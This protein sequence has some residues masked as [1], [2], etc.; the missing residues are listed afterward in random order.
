[1][2]PEIR[3]HSAKLTVG[4]R[5]WEAPVFSSREGI[6][7]FTDVIAH[8]PAVNP[9]EGR[10]FE[11]EEGPDRRM[12]EEETVVSRPEWQSFV[13]MLMTHFPHMGLE[14][15]PAMDIGGVPPSRVVMS[16]EGVDFLNQ[17][18]NRWYEGGVEVST[19]RV[20]REGD[21]P[22]DP[23]QEV[24]Y[25]LPFRPVTGLNVI[26]TPTVQRS[27]VPQ[28]AMILR[29]KEKFGWDAG[30]EG[31]GRYL[32]VCV[33]EDLVPRRSQRRAHKK[34]HP[35]LRWVGGGRR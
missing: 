1:M 18:I 20:W 27:L 26:V 13:V 15:L 3:A 12:A 4:T 11:E 33:F 31:M 34:A 16:S 8:S 23:V 28:E 10:V 6:R 14:I 32:R 9:S 7:P 29:E 2:H 22:M 30:L 5:S 25:E 21:L 35:L 24:Q 19:L 17:F